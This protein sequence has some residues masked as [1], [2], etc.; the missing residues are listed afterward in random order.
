MSVIVDKYASASINPGDHGE[1]LDALCQLCALGHLEHQNPPKRS[2]RALHC[3]R[4][5]VLSRRGCDGVCLAV[6]RCSEEVSA[7][8][9]DTTRQDIDYMSDFGGV[10]DHAFVI[11]TQ[12]AVGIVVNNGSGFGSRACLN[13]GQEAVTV[14]RKCGR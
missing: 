12:G 8:K 10:H 4:S 13:R 14:V 3:S 2:I 9:R 1:S 6:A 5:L 7:P 11:K